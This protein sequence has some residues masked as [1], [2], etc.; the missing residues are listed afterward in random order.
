[1]YNQ[2]D[3]LCQSTGGLRQIAGSRHIIKKADRE[4][5]DLVS[6]YL[7]PIN[8]LDIKESESNAIVGYAFLD[9][10]DGLSPFHNTA[11]LR[12]SNLG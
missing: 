1:V 3:R 10:D 7:V 12:Q 2:G 8:D 4:Y 9:L 11:L 6:L 5:A